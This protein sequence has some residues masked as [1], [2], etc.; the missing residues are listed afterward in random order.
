MSPW[1][2]HPHKIKETKLLKLLKHYF[3]NSEHWW[4]LDSSITFQL[5]FTQLNQ[6][7]F[8][9]S[10]SLGNWSN[11]QIAKIITELQ[12][13]EHQQILSSKL[14]QYKENYFS[15]VNTSFQN[16]IASS[17]TSTS[18]LHGRPCFAFCFTQKRNNNFSD[19]YVGSDGIIVI[20]HHPQNSSAISKIDRHLITAYRGPQKIRKNRRKLVQFMINKS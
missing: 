8:V 14:Q 12:K 11:E 17:Q 15:L 10:N 19:I 1:V 16:T 4:E 6:I 5:W 9:Y 2:L 18:T 7:R 13:N 20:T 3:S